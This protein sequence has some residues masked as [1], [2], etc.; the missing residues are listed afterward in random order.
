MASDENETPTFAVLVL[1]YGDS[2]ALLQRCLDSIRTVLPS[3]YVTE[4]RIGLN[5]PTP[6]LEQVARDWLAG[7]RDLTFT[8]HLDARLPWRHLIV[9]Y[10][11]RAPK[12]PM[13]RRLLYDPP[14]QSPF[15]MWFDDDSFIRPAKRHDFFAR[16]A[17][18]LQGGCDLIGQ[19]W[20]KAL[21]PGQAAWLAAQPW[22]RGATFKTYKDGDSVSFFQGAWWCAWAQAL[23]C[24]DYPWPEL[25][26][27][28]GDVMLGVLAA[29]QDWDLYAVKGRDGADVAINA[30]ADGHDSRGPRRGLDTLPIGAKS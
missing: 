7:L 17:G 24:H 4:V 11:E 5:A 9:N 27:N 21:Q 2:V 29:A 16:Y 20:R 13:M 12:Y 25:D 18:L 30:D 22:S 3:S 1:G 26:H 10:A 23:R 8:S 28:G 6:E 15:V 19:R 14:L